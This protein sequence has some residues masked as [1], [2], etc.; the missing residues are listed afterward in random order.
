LLCMQTSTK[1]LKFV[2]LSD[3]K[4]NALSGVAAL[5]GTLTQRKEQQPFDM[6]EIDFK[7]NFVS[8][9]FGRN[10]VHLQ[11]KCLIAQFAYLLYNF[12]IST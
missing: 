8:F 7:D 4:T 5:Q 3:L 10:V 6:R 12:L 2:D 9:G 11:S 1:L